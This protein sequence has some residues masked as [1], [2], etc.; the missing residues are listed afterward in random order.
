MHTFFLR[1]RNNGKKSNL[2]YAKYITYFREK[3]PLLDILK[4]IGHYIVKAVL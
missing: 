1:T 2:L 4:K 3:Y